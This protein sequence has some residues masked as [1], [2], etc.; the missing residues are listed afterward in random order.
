MYE[1]SGECTTKHCFNELY[2]TL[3]WGKIE[4]VVAAVFYEQVMRHITT[5]K[6]K[7]NILK[8]EEAL[9]YTVEPGLTV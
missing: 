1:Y 7:I 4:K 3:N 9:Q 6:L 5:K 2:R 8:K